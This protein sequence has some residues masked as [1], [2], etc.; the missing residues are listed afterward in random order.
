MYYYYPLSLPVLDL[1]KIE[2]Y[3]DKKEKIIRLYSDE[4]IFQVKKSK[5]FRIHYIDDETNGKR[6]K[7]GKW[8]FVSDDSKIILN[9]SNKIPYNFEKREFTIYKKG[10]MTIE[11]Q[12]SKVANMYFTVDSPEIHGIEE[13]II[14]CMKNICAKV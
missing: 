8:D 11:I 12:K 10:L 5:I 4:G 9:L 3:C 14:N 1:D 7:V 6:M 13:D 2:R